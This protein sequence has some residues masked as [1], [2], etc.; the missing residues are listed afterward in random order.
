M[1]VA[2]LATLALKHAHNHLAEG[3]RHRR[4]RRFR[5]SIV[6]S[7]QGLSHFRRAISPSAVRG[8]GGLLLAVPPP[9]A[10]M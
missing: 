2:S 5:D 7:G 4:L 9:L 6:S 10:D 1:R 8:F 3:R